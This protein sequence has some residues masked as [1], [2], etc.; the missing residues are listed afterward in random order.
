MGSNLLFHVLIRRRGN[1]RK[2]NKKDVCL[3]IGKRPQAIVIFL[4]SSIEQSKCV[5]LA[6][7]HNSHSIVVKHLEYVLQLRNTLNNKDPNA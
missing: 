6:T 3:R 1:D 5:R 2:A 7:N 4:T